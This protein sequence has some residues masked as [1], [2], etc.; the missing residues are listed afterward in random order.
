LSYLDIKVKKVFDSA[1]KAVITSIFLKCARALLDMRQDTRLGQLLEAIFI[2]L[3]QNPNKPSEEFLPLYDLQE[4]SLTNLGKNEAAQALLQQV[5]RIK[6]E[7]LGK[8][9]PDTL[10]TMSN[11][12]LV[13][14]R[15]GKYADAEA[16]NRQTLEILEEV[17]G[18]MHPSTLMS[19]YCLAYLLQSR[20]EYNE[21]SIL[22]K[23]AYT[24][25]KSLLGSEHPTTKA[26]VDHYSV[27][28]NSLE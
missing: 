19:V 27:M 6:E 20:H 13:L 24:G 26:C 2:E 10:A 8:T 3:R 23:R 16:M 25:F 28:L 18:K 12:A 4:R 7:V 1:S 9:H 22:Y 11:L 17:L 14:S 21:A 5:I 15:Q